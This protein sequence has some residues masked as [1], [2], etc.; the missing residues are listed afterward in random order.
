M[1]RK[2]VSVRRLPSGQPQMD[3]A[4]I[5]ALESYEV[6]FH[7]VPLPKTKVADTKAGPS[8]QQYGPQPASSSWQQKQSTPYYK[9][10]G[11]GKTKGK[12][13]KTPNILPKELQNKGCVNQDEHGCSFCFNLNWAG[14]KT[15]PMAPS[16]A[17]VVSLVR[18]ERVP[19]PT[20]CAGS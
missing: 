13:K 2:D 12:G 5:Q 9:G 17:K 3:T 19:R 8:Q 14:A 15:Q 18:E 4:L 20:L 1:I 7:L 10:G 16:A 6:S 11:K